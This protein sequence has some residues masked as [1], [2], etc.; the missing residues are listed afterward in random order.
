MK[1]SFIIQTEDTMYFIDSFITEFANQNNLVVYRCNTDADSIR[2]MQ[3]TIAYP[4]IMGKDYLVFINRLDLANNTCKSLLLKTLEEGNATFVLTVETIA[5][6]PE[7]ILNRCKEIIYPR[8]TKQE[9]KTFLQRNLDT[10]VEP[11]VLDDKL[12]ETII[13]ISTYYGDIEKLLQYNIEKFMVFVRLF[14]DYVNIANLAN[15]MSI[16]GKLK[17]KED[18]DGYDI[19]L[20]AKC[21]NRYAMLTELNKKSFAIM[22]ASSF[23]AN[24]L[25]NNVNKTICVDQYILDIRRFSK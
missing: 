7:T 8:P 19:W 15:L 11:L 13:D 24:R 10:R 4:N 21:L 12:K 14:Y 18:Q 17:T 22:N 6:L 2:N 25:A 3:Q 20:F 1:E 23:L 9:L 5:S 16:T